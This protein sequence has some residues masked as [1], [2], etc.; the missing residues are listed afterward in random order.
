MTGCRHIA[1]AVAVVPDSADSCLECV[2]LG[3]HWVHLRLCLICGHVGCCDNSKNQHA[4]R[5]FEASSH[6]IIAS[7][8]PGEAWRYCYIDDIML[9]S[10]EPAR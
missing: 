1:A 6:P 9:P 4:R 8:E 3:D 7:Y 10:G 5:H 2:A